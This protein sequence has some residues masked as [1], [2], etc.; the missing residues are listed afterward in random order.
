MVPEIA[1]RL[2]G[3]SSLWDETLG[4]PEI[5]VAVLDGPVD[6]SHPCFRG[7]D[8]RRVATLVNDPAGTGPMS[9]HGTH[10]ASEIFGQPESPV[11][12]I[13]PRCRGLILPVFRDERT[14]RLPQLDLARAIEQAV[15]EGAHVINISGGERAPEGQGDA[16]LERAV[17][18]CAENHVLVVAAAGNDG[19]ECLHVPAAL[20]SVLAVGA[21]GQNGEPLD[22]S[23][24]GEAYKT[25][26]LL[27]PGQNILG[28]VPGGGTARLTGSSF[29]TPL[30][31][32]IAALLLSIERKSGREADPLAIG[33]IILKTARPCVPSDNL[34][35]RRYLVG[36]L[37]IPGAYA[38]TREGGEKA[39]PNSEQVP[40]AVQSPAAVAPLQ[41]SSLVRAAESS[42]VAV[43]GEPA[44]RSMA[45][46]PAAQPVPSPA[47][48]APSAPSQGVAPSCS[49]AVGAQ[50]YV[51]A[52]GNISFDFGTEARR[53]S[54][55][56]LMSN[57]LITRPDGTTVSVPPNP[58]DT[59]QLL[60]YLEGK[61]TDPRFPPHPWESTKLIWTLNLDLTPIYAIEAETPYAE[62]VYKGLR[63]A[64]RGESLA[65]TEANYVS[66]V[67]VSG[68]LTNRTVRLF[69]GQVVPVVRAQARGLY[70][71]NENQLIDAIVTAVNLTAVPPVPDNAD[72]A[73]KDAAAQK[74][75]QYTAAAQTALRNFL[76]KVYYQL[77]NLGQ[78]S[79]DRAL[80]Y[81]ATNAFAA[82]QGI[83]KAMNPSS[84]GIV[85]PVAGQTGIYTLD[86]ITVSKSP[87]CRM[88]S[89]CW[90]VQLLFFDPENDQRAETAIQLTVDV[91]DEMPVSLAP[92]R[93]FVV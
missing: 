33:E 82:A 47:A 67:S 62:E 93:F 65:N 91:S 87:F 56:Q 30:V 36:A 46:T 17:R 79:P 54:F 74:T 45:V 40:V 12:G 8:L 64:L 48:T 25:N 41:D 88:D 51:F 5:C 69:S 89:D 14:S 77:R 83:A 76:D 6:F 26:G 21:M 50:S 52:V 80:N 71:W 2:P 3:L 49:C 39:M 32:G 59:G 75:A 84:Y 9:T 85:L 44:N 1:S 28:A 78:A 11:A 73:T 15:Q 72:Q 34:D 18:L 24:W 68:V 61:H 70:S 37:N 35:C 29:A 4:D 90:D 66:R 43:G 23:N 31:A 22:I 7:A 27:A 16:M 86:T 55:R 42:P 92:I 60:D 58:Y 63:A 81:T 38:L 53:D 10:V 57:V 20:P 19:C 13:A